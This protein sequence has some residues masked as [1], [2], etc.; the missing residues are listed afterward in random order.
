[1]NLSNLLVCGLSFH[2]TPVEVR[3][4]VSIPPHRLEDALAFLMELPGVRECMILSTCN[5]SELYLS[6]E[7]WIDGKELFCRF[8]RV[9]CGTDLTSVCNRIYA[10]KGPDAV[11]HSFRVAASLDS[12]VLGEPQILGQM[13]AAFRE[14]EDR[15]CIGRDLHQWIPPAFAAAKQ[16]RNETGI[17]EAAVSISY[18]AVQLAKK[19]F[20]NLAGRRVL[21][22]GAGK[23][24]EL[25]A[26]HLRDAGVRLITVTNRT[27]S[28]AKEVAGA[29]SGLAIGFDHVFEEI[30]KADIV[31]CSTD[32]P[33]PILMAQDIQGI[34]GRRPKDPLLLL[35]ISVPRN[36]DPLVAE[37]D[38]VYLFNIDDLE[39]VVQVNR[40]ARKDDARC[41]ET[42]LDRAFEKFLR[43]NIDSRIAL[44]IGA[45]QSQVYS[46]CHAEFQRLV[47]ASPQMTPTDREAVE[48]ML[49]RVAQKVI[50][51]AIME[52]KAIKRVDACPKGPSLAEELLTSPGRS[53]PGPEMAAQSSS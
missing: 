48:L 10:L 1:V 31:V 21:L 34:L 30:A 44:N 17:C 27:L 42:I 46:I 32:A 11:K 15:R 14:A 33:H 24:G 41:A 4:R 23:M 53:F 36:V 35:D 47:Q 51:H 22:L 50:H 12:L 13:K 40:Q 26:L 7:S 25:A 20:D 49:H 45:I 28:R 16:V 8:A 18:A 3:E 52:L 5:R 9:I 43:H 38:G 39:E 29:C 6:V 19:I 2:Q 37:L